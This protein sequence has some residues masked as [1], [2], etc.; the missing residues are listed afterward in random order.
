MN[1]AGFQDFYR[2]TAR[3]LWGYIYRVV[4]NAAL[5]EDLV[6]E[7]FLRVLKTPLP[8]RPSPEL[9]AYLYRTA[10]NL[11]T[12]HFRRA[13]RQSRLRAELASEERAE[14]T[15][16]ADLGHDVA[17]TFLEL[18]PQERTLLWLAYVEESE[19]R[20]IAASLGLKEKSIKVLLFR[21]RGKLARLLQKKGLSTEVES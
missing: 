13:G 20:E 8:M 7:A 9:R 6:Q 19:H 21:A 17:R 2:R 4:G 10:T 14:T 12:D 5:A 15:A 3:P 1:E 16:A 11:I 18:K